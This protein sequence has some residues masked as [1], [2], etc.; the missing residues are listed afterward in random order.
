M[1]AASSDGTRL[2]VSFM[3]INTGSGTVSVIDSVSHEKLHSI[4]VGIQPFHIALSPDNSLLY[5]S[6]FGSDT[7]SII[8]TV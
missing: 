8:A 6:N 7:V 4:N 2:Y 3:N 5:V 1:E